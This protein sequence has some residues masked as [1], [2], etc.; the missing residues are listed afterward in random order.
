MKVGDLVKR[1]VLRTFS[2]KFK[3]CNWLAIIVGFDDDGDLRLLYANPGEGWENREDVD[4]IS[5]WELIDES[6]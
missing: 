5:A 2:S 1:K 6:R 3:D 4:Y